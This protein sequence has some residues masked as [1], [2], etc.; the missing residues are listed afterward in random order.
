MNEPLPLEENLNQ[1][2][3]PQD[4]IN[5]PFYKKYKIHLSVAGALLIVG[6]S[7]FSHYK[8]ER[9]KEELIKSLDQYAQNLTLMGGELKYDAV[10]C[11]GIFSSDCEIEKISLS[12]L[13]QEQLSL[14]SLRLGDVESLAKFKTFG[15]GENVDASIDIEAKGLALPKPIIA[16]LI[17]SN[18]SNA[19][20]QNTITKLSTIDLSLKGEVEGNT[21]HLKHLTID[22]LRLDNAIMPIEF[23]MKAKE[24]S[25]QAPDSMV[26]EEFALR[27]ENRSISDVTYESVKSFVS[28]LSAGDQAVFLKEFSLS[29]A[30]MN[31]RAKATKAINDAMAKRFE[32]DLP[33]TPGV[34]E[35][36]LIR[37]MAKMLKG[38]AESI[39]LEGKNQNNLTMVQIQNALQQS[40]TMSEEEAKK[41]MDDKFRIEVET[42]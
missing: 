15:E 28:T 21:M 38:E 7:A 9:V 40:S 32:A 18:V 19:F 12:M 22:S 26:L 34:V 13:G 30:D 6:M 1:E 24:V 11:S 8:N 31:D 42:H 5:E 17:A 33:S 37:A 25:S 4:H 35:K 29:P 16:Q 14:Q 23:S 39:T 27:T 36:E 2:Q 41:F 3:Q 10:D 20:Q